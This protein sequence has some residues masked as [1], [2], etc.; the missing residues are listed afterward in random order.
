MSVE[1]PWVKASQSGL[2]SLSKGPLHL[3]LRV[4]LIAA[5]RLQANGCAP[6][7]RGELARIMG[8]KHSQAITRAIRDAVSYG[9][10]E[11]DSKPECLRPNRF[12]FQMSF[13]STRKECSI[14][15]WTDEASLCE[16]QERSKEGQQITADQSL[17]GERSVFT[18]RTLSVKK[19]LHSVFAGDKP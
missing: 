9:F 14:H 2:E 17:D 18:T 13:G 5:A 8:N 7:K 15:P 4:A 19:P 12:L 10:L 11:A 16:E 1:A 3:W 6:F